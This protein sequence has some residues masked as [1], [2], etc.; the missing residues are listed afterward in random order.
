MYIRAQIHSLKRQLRQHPW[1]GARLASLWIKEGQLDKA[2]ALLRRQLEQFPAYPSAR[3]ELAHLLLQKGDRPQAFLELLR[4]S[5]MSEG[6]LA[7]FTEMRD[8]ES[9]AQGDSQLLKDLLT[10]AWGRDRLSRS[11]REA[12]RSEGLLEEELYRELF[13][14]TEQE[15][16][17]RDREIDQLIQRLIAEGQVAGIASD[18]G[19][20][21]ESLPA[22]ESPA[23]VDEPRRIGSRSLAALYERQGY[24]EKAIE[25]LQGLLASCEGEEERAELQQWLDRLAAGE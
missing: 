14:P 17:Q 19:R 18:G 12:M 15:R 21:E 3:M 5:A 23:P 24:P 2:E 4:A 25:V 22:P 13:V 6:P 9:E 1:L 16:R 7:A 10:E 20:P 11:L 8:L